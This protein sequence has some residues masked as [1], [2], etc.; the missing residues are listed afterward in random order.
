MNYFSLVSFCS[1]FGVQ[2][3]FDPE[4]AVKY[5]IHLPTVSGSINFQNTSIMS[6]IRNSAG[7]WHRRVFETDLGLPAST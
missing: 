7:V 2:E 3:G 4:P 6:L 1:R 5:A